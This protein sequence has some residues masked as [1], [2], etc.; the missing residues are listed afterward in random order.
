MKTVFQHIFIDLCNWSAYFN[1]LHKYQCNNHLFECATKTQ[2]YIAKIK[3]RLAKEYKKELKWHSNKINCE[4]K[5]CKFYRKMCVI[6][7]SKLFY[8]KLFQHLKKSQNR[9]KALKKHLIYTKLFRKKNFL[10]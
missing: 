7:K 1:A 9:I 8:K 10:L 5:K 3:L 2:K 6:N 4:K